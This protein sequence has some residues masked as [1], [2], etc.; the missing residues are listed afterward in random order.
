MSAENEP[1]DSPEAEECDYLAGQSLGKGQLSEA[2]SHYREAVAIREGVLGPDH[3]Q[4]AD[5]LVRLAGLVGWCQSNSTEADALWRRSVG[6]YEQ[7]YQALCK[8]KG[9]LFEHVLMGLTGTLS[10]LA[11]RA[12]DRGEADEAE[13]LFRRIATLVEESYGTDCAWFPPSLLTFARVLIQQGKDQE[14]ERRLQKAIDTVGSIDEWLNP[15]CQ[16]LLAELYVRQGRVVEAEARF[17]ESVELL[18]KATRPLPTLLASVLE[19]L[20]QLC[21]KTGRVPEAERLEER[22]KDVRGAVP[23]G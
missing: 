12:F 10:N 8:G 20:A 17:R 14:A 4:V 6:I 1:P 21:R 9:E 18:E 7:H 13:R 23:A 22:A 3:Y 16:R 19:D 2:V 5:S 15:E 11:S